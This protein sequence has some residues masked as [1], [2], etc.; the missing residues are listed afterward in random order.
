M[1]NRGCIPSLTQHGYFFE[2]DA[3]TENWGEPPHINENAKPLYAKFE[4]DP[5]AQT[6]TLIDS[7]NKELFQEP[8]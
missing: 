1:G 2:C 8:R 3:T 5:D 4:Y 7:V 6:F